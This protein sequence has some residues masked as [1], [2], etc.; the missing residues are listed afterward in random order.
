ML[1][2]LRDELLA[3]KNW[4]VGD[5]LTETERQAV[6]NREVRALEIMIEIEEFTSK[7]SRGQSDFQS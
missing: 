6:I 2:R 5:L 4:P 3:I 1:E 7:E